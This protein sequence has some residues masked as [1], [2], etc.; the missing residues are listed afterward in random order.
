M[1]ADGGRI[2]GVCTDAVNDDRCDP[3]PSTVI[4]I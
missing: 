2:L 1:V 3:P 4:P